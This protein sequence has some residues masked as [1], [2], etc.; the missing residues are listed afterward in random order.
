MHYNVRGSFPTPN[1]YAEQAKA[2]LPTKPKTAYY[3]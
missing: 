1:P 2:A 3:L